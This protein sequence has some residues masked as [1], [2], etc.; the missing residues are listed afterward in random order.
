MVKERVDEVPTTNGESNKVAEEIKE[1]EPPLE[2][3][4][5]E[6]PKEDFDTP[7]VRVFFLDL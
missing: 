1:P 7:A 3:S 6:E 4:M 5:E 2:V